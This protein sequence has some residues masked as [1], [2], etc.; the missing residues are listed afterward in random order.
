MADRLKVVL[1]TEGTY[2]YYRG[3]VSTWAD[4]LIRKLGNIDFRI[5][6]IM[7]HPYITINFRLP[8]NVSEL[9]NVPLWGTEEP[10]EYVSGL[11]FS[12]IFARK[13]K[14][15]SDI[16]ERVTL[17]IHDITRAIYYK[18]PDLSEIG[19]ELVQLYD[20]FQ[21]YDYRTVFRSR[22]MWDFFYETTLDFYRYEEEKPS[23]YEVVESLRWLYRFF[24]SLLS[25]IREADIYHSSAAAFCGLPCIIAKI[26]KGTKF[27]L[28]EHG[29]YMR[30]QYLFASREKMPIRTKEFFCGLIS[31]VSKL[32]YFFADQVSPVCAH[33]KRW[34]VKLGTAESKI[35]VIYNGIDTDLFR[36]MNVG[37]DDRPTVVMV[38]RV[39][40]LKDIETY[41]RTCSKVREKKPEILFKLYGPVIEKDYYEKCRNLVE[42]LNLKG[43]F[44]FEGLSFTPEIANNEGDVVVLTSISEAFPFA[45]LEGMACEK[46]VISSD[47]GGTREVLEGY[48]FIIKPKDYQA[49]A[50]KIIYVLEHPAEAAAIGIEARQRVENGFRIDDMVRNYMET[51]QSLVGIH[52]S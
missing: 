1:T 20:I 4:I 30:E 15:H 25:P 2:P 18:D 9:I 33:N 44:V 27:L 31:L 29:I 6:A 39:D 35:K 45:V 49:F 38:A 40:H 14:T 48:G 46:V 32:N 13:L 5:L 21:E 24:I 8:P 7:M 37:R 11:N 43:N 12:D 42:R 36:K 34:E 51:Y 19:N 17:I 10:T 16:I 52:A 47:V 22:H 23:V 28:T 41:I 3:G 50:E 26:K